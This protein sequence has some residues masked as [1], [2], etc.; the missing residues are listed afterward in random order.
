MWFRVDDLF[1][2]HTKVID[3]ANALGGPNALGRIAA[4]W[5]EG[6]LYAA[7]HLTDG[8]IPRRV[9][10]RFL[11]D[12]APLDV[13]AALVRGRIWVPE[14]DGF[15]VHDWTDFQPSGSDVK[16]KRARDRDRKRAALNGSTGNIPR[17]IH[18]ESVATPRGIDPDSEAL[19]R[20]RDPVPVPQRSKAQEPA[21]C[22]SVFELRQAILAATHATVERGGEF[23]NPDG[24]PNAAAISAEVRQIA[25]HDLRATWDQS[26]EIEAIVI[27]ALETRARRAE[28]TAA[29]DRFHAREATALRALGR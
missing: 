5:L 8:F 29:R 25:A 26:R 20:A 23:V 22:A 19:A 16:A 24:T 14:G 2:G 6:G 7:R 27:A 10:E 12:D 13:A 4:V 15:R 11:T 17:G 21:P 1:L 9:V 28:A 18:A 3:A